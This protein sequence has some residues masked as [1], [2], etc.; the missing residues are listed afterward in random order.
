MEI[1]NKEEREKLLKEKAREV[2]E[3]YNFIHLLS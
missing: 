2:V 1:Y 3:K